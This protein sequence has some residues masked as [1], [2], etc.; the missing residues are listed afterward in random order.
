MSGDYIFYFCAGY[1][2]ALFLSTDSDPANKVLIASEPDSNPPAHWIEGL[3]DHGRGYRGDPPANISVP[4]HLD[5]GGRYYIEALMKKPSGYDL[6]PGGYDYFGATWR[7]PGTPPVRTYGPPITGQYLVSRLAVGPPVIIA[8]PKSLTVG[9]LQPAT[10]AFQLDG[11]PPF[12]FQ[13][14]RNGQAIPGATGVVYAAMATL[15]DDGASFS[16]AISNSLGSVTS[17]NAVL[18][19]VPKTVPPAL[20]SAKS[21]TLEKV[22]VVFSEAVTGM[23]ATNVANYSITAAQGS[24]AVISAE[25]AANPA[26]VI[27]ATERQIEGTEYTLTVNGITDTAAAGNPIAAN[28]QATFTPSFPNEFVGPFPSWADV[29]RDFGARGDGVTD[30][31]AQIQ[32]ALDSIGISNQIGSDQRPA[33]LY[34]PAGTYRITAGLQFFRVSAPVF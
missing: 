2:G 20:V 4:I 22:A 17:S 9:E 5:A 18:A 14:F 28:S 32:Q 24:L 16:V 29:K 11:S 6:S 34:F 27:L 7:I 1:P 30:D 10:F 19:V 33:V 26:Q 8:Q 21:V 31:T 25:L 12:S 15:S 23:T 3:T 13:W